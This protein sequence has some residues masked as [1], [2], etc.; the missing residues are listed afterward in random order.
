MGSFHGDELHVLQ[1]EEF[2][3]VTLVVGIDMKQLQSILYVTHVLP[4]WNKAVYMHMCEQ[5]G[6]SKSLNEPKKIDFRPS[7]QLFRINSREGELR[8][9]LGCPKGR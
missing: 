6:S 8:F 2:A 9:L 4:E 3:W 1:E 7:N 5:K